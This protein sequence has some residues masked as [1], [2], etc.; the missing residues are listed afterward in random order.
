MKISRAEQI[1]IQEVLAY[2]EAWGFGNL[3]SH[4]QTAWAK[5]LMG[6]HGMSEAHAREAAGGPGYPF[7]M[8]DDIVERGEWDHSG[9]RY[10]NVK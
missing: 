8:Q 10:A 1:A 2:G 6:L 9:K 4:L 5:R 3:I 7:T